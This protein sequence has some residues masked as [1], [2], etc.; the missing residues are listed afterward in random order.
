MCFVYSL[1]IYLSVLFLFFSLLHSDIFFSLFIFDN[2]VKLST[3]PLPLKCSIKLI[4]ICMCP[5]SGYV[6]PVATFFHTC[7]LSNNP[8]LLPLPFRLLLECVSTFL[9]YPS[10]CLFLSLHMYRLLS[11][12][13]FAEF[14]SR[15]MHRYFPGNVNLCFSF[16][17]SILSCPKSCRQSRAAAAEHTCPR[18]DQTAEWQLGGKR[19]VRH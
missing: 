17:P 18:W 14:I 12:P 6:S 9:F 19:A 4:S 5:F 3:I 10:A 16:C 1:F 15:T 2:S 11:C 7:R 13:C 8:P